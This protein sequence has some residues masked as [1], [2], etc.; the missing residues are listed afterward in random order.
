MGQYAR[1]EA[2]LDYHEVD[3]YYDSHATAED[4]MGHTSYH[5]DL[6]EYL[7]LVLRWQFRGQVCAIYDDLNHYQT[8]DKMEYPVAPDIAVIKGE[9]QRTRRSWT[10]DATGPAPQ[11][12]FEIVSK[13][14][15]RNDLYKK[16]QKYYSMGVEEYYLYDPETPQHLKYKGRRLV[17][18]KL[19]RDKKILEEMQPEQQGR[20]WSEQLQSFLIPDDDYLRLYDSEGQLRLTEAEAREQHERELEQQAW[21]LEQKARLS[22]KKAR[23]SEEKARLSDEKARQSEEKARLSDEKARQSEEKARLSDEK[24]RLLAEKLR[25]LGMNPDEF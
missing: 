17:G 23:Q 18:W 4:L 8:L 21:S 19:N 20:L 25:S 5:S 14:T 2:A 7:K 6:V 12:V 1:D 11:V 24:V 16:P 13:E 9:A 3:Y 10:V 15:W 22:E